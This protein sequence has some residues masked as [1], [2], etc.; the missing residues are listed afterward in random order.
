MEFTTVRMGKPV[1]GAAR[2]R[3]GLRQ[4]IGRQML[5]AECV[6]NSHGTLLLMAKLEVLWE[7]EH[8]LLIFSMNEEKFGEIG[9]EATNGGLP[10]T[11]VWF[12]AIVF[13]MKY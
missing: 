4:G 5:P 13:K 2:I 1:R 3:A 12:A 6:I 8:V 9:L 10:K 7:K 11:I